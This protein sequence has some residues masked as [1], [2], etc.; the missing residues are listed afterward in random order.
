MNELR[1]L[2]LKHCGRTSRA[3]SAGFQITKLQCKPSMG[4]AH[5]CYVVQ[6]HKSMQYCSLQTFAHPLSRTQCRLSWGRP[7]SHSCSTALNAE[8]QDTKGAGPH[9]Q[10]FSAQLQLSS[11]CM[12]TH[13][14]CRKGGTDAGATLLGLPRS[15]AAP[16][17]VCILVMLYGTGRSSGVGNVFSIMVPRSCQNLG[18]CPSSGTHDRL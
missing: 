3:N 2:C 7:P 14:L 16:R 4:E 12:D 11:V 6:M 17:R 5:F 15:G 13:V 10:L 8:Q 1:L 9:R 18:L